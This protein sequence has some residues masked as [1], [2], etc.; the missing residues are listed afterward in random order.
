VD[1]TFDACLLART[2]VSIIAITGRVYRR[3]K[4]EADD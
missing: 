1:E 2:N 3:G 4:G